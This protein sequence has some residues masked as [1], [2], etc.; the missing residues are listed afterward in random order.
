MQKISPFLWFDDQAEDAA[1]LY[2]SVF[3][4]SRIVSTSRYQEGL[5]KPAGTLMSVEFILDGEEFTAINGGPQFTFTPA[6]SFSVMCDTQEEVDEYWE[7][8]T[9]GGEEGQCGW[10]IDRFGL[11]WQ[12]VPKVLGK[13][14]GSS[15][16]AAAQ[17][18][19][20]AMLGMKKLDIAAL[21]AAYDNA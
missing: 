18:A 5:P 20:T 11:S 12:I 15:D 19:T 16:R 13:L 7:K 2:V 6:I 14:M 21:Q 17:R 9:D 1:N 8:L 10:L 3:K 4:N